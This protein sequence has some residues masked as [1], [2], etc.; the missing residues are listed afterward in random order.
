MSP[1][2]QVLGVR[3]NNFAED[4]IQPTAGVELRFECICDCVLI[5]TG[6]IQVIMAVHWNPWKAMKNHHY[7]GPSEVHIQS[8]RMVDSFS[9]DSPGDSSVQLGL[10]T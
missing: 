5:G 6:K 3:K 7:L 1:H 9:K 2:S 4:K 10:K 8:P